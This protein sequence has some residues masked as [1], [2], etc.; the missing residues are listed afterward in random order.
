MI[1]PQDALATPAIHNF[2]KYLPIT[3]DYALPVTGS[4]Q[5]QKKEQNL[6]VRFVLLTQELRQRLNQTGHHAQRLFQVADGAFCNRTVLREDWEAQNVSVVARWSTTI[7]PFHR[8]Q[9]GFVPVE[10]SGCR[11]W[12]ELRSGG[13]EA[14][15]ISRWVAKSWCYEPL[16]RLGVGAGLG[17]GLRGV[18]P[19]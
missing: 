13:L 4:H 14:G 18:G 15:T 2:W 10:A 8:R 6:S 9:L 5:R 11:Y 7:I 1:D 3:L 17:C 16:S 19:P 12:W